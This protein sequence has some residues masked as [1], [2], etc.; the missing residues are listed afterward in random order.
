MKGPDRLHT[1]QTACPPTTNVA[2]TTSGTRHSGKLRD[3]IPP[4][5]DWSVT[6]ANR[7]ARRR[8]YSR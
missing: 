3:S 8:R 4:W 2:P 7:A 6:P 5:E 1:M